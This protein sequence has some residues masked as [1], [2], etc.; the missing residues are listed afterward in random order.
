MDDVEYTPTYQPP[1]EGKPPQHSSTPRRARAPKRRGWLIALIIS[2]S[3][4]VVLAGGGAALYYSGIIQSF[5]PAASDDY[6]GPGSGQ[7]YFT[8]SEEAT[9]ESVAIDLQKQGVI[10]SSKTFYSLLLEQET[11]PVLTPGVFELKK[12]MSNQGA[13]SALTDGKHLVQNTVVIPEGSVLT[14]VVAA[15]TEGT[16][17]SSDD[18]SAAMADV[19]GYGLPAEATT[20]EGF[21]FPAT[22]NFSPNVTAHEVVQ[23]LVDRTFEAL[24]AAGVAPADRYNTIVFASLIQKEA[25]LRDDYYKVARVFTNRMNPELWPTGLLESDATVAYGS[26]HTERVSTTDA[27]RADAGNPYNTYVHPGMVFAPISNPGD[28]AIDAALHPAD[29]PWLFFVT[30]NLDTGETIFSTTVDEHDAAVRT[31]LDWMEEHP[32]YQ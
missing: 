18:I 24:D 6:P 16:D 14:D 4:V 30:W 21:L 2:V 13:L 31:W 11:S 23:T 10:K 7:L 29:G 19:G 27:E 26:G 3:S 12:Q 25:G 9:W 17:L 8:V 15:I 20:L 32:E 5:L 22:Y 1:S 28:L